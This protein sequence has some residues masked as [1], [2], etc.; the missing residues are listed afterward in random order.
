MMLH[1]ALVVA[2]SFAAASC[3]LA[4]VEIIDRQ[5]GS[6]GESA[7]VYP[8][9]F[10]NIEQTTSVVEPAQP[11]VNVAELYYQMQVMQQEVLELRGLVELQTHQ[12]KQLKQQRLDDYV[13]LD[14]RMSAMSRGTSSQTPV[15]NQAS[16]RPNQA[17]PQATVSAA[18]TS[19][20][21]NEIA[22]Y[23]SGTKLILVDKDYDTGILRLQEHLELYPQGRYRG[24]AQ[25]WLGEV[26]LAKSELT[27]AKGWFEQLLNEAPLHSKALDAKYKLGTVCF[28]L[29]DTD[30]AKQLLQE[31]S[32]A[33]GNSAKLAANYLK[34]NF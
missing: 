10:N 13:D 4:E 18:V 11:G 34:Q 5:V 1:K 14:R 9:E 19:S 6:P 16:S 22:H 28:Q 12:I 32:Q 24:N 33:G 30:R 3:V 8:G 20:P 17:S 29:G 27:D 21:A 31:V 23:K 25:Y 7:P 26:Y 2:A 15:Q